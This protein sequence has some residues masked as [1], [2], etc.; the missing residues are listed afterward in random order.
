MRSLIIAIL[1]AVI[2]AVP[3][4]CEAQDREIQ[5][6]VSQADAATNPQEKLQYANKII[7]KNNQ[8]W[9]G[10]TLGA[11]ARLMM[12]DYEKAETNALQATTLDPEITMSWRLLALARLNLNK[13]KD[14]IDAATKGLEKAG[15]RAEQKDEI[16]LLYCFRAE[17]HRLLGN[18]YQALQDL[19]Q[20]LLKN[21][22]FSPALNARLG[23]LMDMDQKDLAIKDCEMLGKLSAN[24]PDN[25]EL[26]MDYGKAQYIV[27]RKAEAIQTFNQVLKKRPNFATA[28]LLRGKA[29]RLTGKFHAALEDMEKAHKLDPQNLEVRGDLAILYWVLNKTEKSQKELTHVL[30]HEPK[31]VFFHQLQMRVYLEQNELDA[32]IDEANVTLNLTATDKETAITYHLAGKALQN[33]GNLENAM[34]CYDKAILHDPKLSE[35]LF[36]RAQLHSITGN[37]TQAVADCNTG[38]EMDSDSALG[39]LLRGRA[40][41]QIYLD[42]KTTFGPLP[43]NN[44]KTSY[45][46]ALEDIKKAIKLAPKSHFATWGYVSLANL[47]RERKEHDEAISWTTKAVT[48][49]I[50]PETK[51][52]YVPPLAAAYVIRAASRHTQKNDEAAKEDCTQAIKLDEKYVGAYVE[53]AGCLRALHQYDSAIEDCKRAIHLQPFLARAYYERGF[54]SLEKYCGIGAELT[55]TSVDLSPILRDMTGRVKAPRHIGKTVIYKTDDTDPSEAK[56]VR[57]RPYVPEPVVQTAQKQE[58]HALD[59]AIQD[60]EIAIKNAYKPYSSV[61]G[62]ALCLVEQGR[63]KEAKQACD[64]ILSITTQDEKEVSKN[65]EKAKLHLI[66]AKIHY[67]VGNIESG[68]TDAQTAAKMKNTSA[69][70][71]LLEGYGYAIRGEWDLCEKKCNKGLQ[72]DAESPVTAKL[73]LLAY[74]ARVRHEEVNKVT[75]FLAG[76]VQTKNLSLKQ[77]PGPLLQALIDGK[78]FK[79]FQSGLETTSE[80]HILNKRIC[81][82][83]YYFALGDYTDGHISLAREKWKKAIATGAKQCMEYVLTANELCRFGS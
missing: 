10:W 52:D 57:T 39:Y 29:R 12:N 71:Y 61:Q 49:P 48:M 34:G 83:L 26:M 37:P 79:Q 6:W 72:F 54:A 8:L 51:S 63:F 67:A 45:Q 78:S 5:Q 31:D 62:L 7:A 41:G 27:G 58:R 69:E 21:E 42:E 11:L 82:S 16:V 14:C 17:S 33:M 4:L 1:L 47:A 73:L 50:N 3:A 40:Y 76:H 23:L 28:F 46:K 44:E 65:E 55:A 24:E 43:P 60:F 18:Q 36:D 32:V 74:V 77:W 68:I 35:A 59:Q 2:L 75:R 53:R 66:R 15:N 30:K 56:A 80:E 19:N 25:I 64:A 81:E 70:S 9:Q 22:K 20:A 38:L 13:H